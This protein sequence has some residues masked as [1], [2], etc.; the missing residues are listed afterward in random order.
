MVSWDWL[1]NKRSSL[2]RSLCDWDKPLLQEHFEDTT[3][4]T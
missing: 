1:F 2:N 3:G 4:K